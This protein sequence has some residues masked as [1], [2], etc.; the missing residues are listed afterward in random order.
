MINKLSCR[1]LKRD[2]T[3]VEAT[4]TQQVQSLKYTCKDRCQ[5]SGLCR[6]KPVKAIPR[7]RPRVKASTQCFQG[8]GTSSSTCQI[9]N[10]EKRKQC[11]QEK[12]SISPCLDPTTDDPIAT[13]TNADYLHTTASTLDES[14]PHTMFTCQ[15]EA[16]WHTATHVWQKHVAPTTAHRQ[17][18]PYMSP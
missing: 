9:F 6:T 7:F 17:Q 11:S 1:G 15:Q 4:T 18:M 16:P 10:A 13:Y 8:D 5:V 3:A 14:I 12:T 2:T